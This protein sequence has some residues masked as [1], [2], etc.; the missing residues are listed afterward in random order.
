MI[1]HLTQFIKRN[2]SAGTPMLVTALMLANAINFVFSAI[3]GRA[4]SLEQF[5]LLTVI[6][7]FWYIASIFLN[8]LGATIIFLIAHEVGKNKRVEGR[9][10]LNTIR[11]NAT[12]IAVAATVVWV[13][14]IPVLMR[15][16]HIDDILSLISVAPL[17]VLGVQV[18]S[19]RA[20]LQGNFFFF[21]AGI[22]IV[23][24]AAA[25]LLLALPFIAFG[26][27]Q[28]VYLSIPLG[29][30][31]TF[32]VA[33]LVIS[34][35]ASLHVSEEEPV[36]FPAKHFFSTV[37]VVFS[38]T[39]FVTFDVLI[40]KHFLS[41][42]QAGVYALLSL[43]GKIVLFLG[44]IF[45]GFIVAY[46]SR[47]IGAGKS[48]TPVFYNILCFSLA[49]SFVGYLLVGPLGQ[50][51]LTLMLGE[52]KAL[53]VLQYSSRYAF[54]IMLFVISN[55]IVSYHTTKKQYQ[56][57]YMALAIAAACFVG[58]LFFHQSIDVFVNVV[59]I[60]SCVGLMINLLMHLRYNTTYEEIDHITKHNVSGYH[61][62]DITRKTDVA[63]CLTA[64]NEEKNI[65]NLL[66]S[67]LNQKT[68]IID[69]KHIVV[70]SFAST[71]NTDAIVNEYAALDPRIKLIQEPE[72]RG[73]ASAINTFLKQYKEP[74]VVVQS[75]DT[76][77]EP[78]CIEYLC[79]PM[80]ADSRI[81]M[82]GGAPVPTNDPHTF[83]GYV[84]H[85]WW[86]FHRNIPRFGEIIAFRNILPEISA[87]TAVDEAW[88]QAKFVQMNYKVVHIDD[89]VVYNKGSDT[90]ADIIK[91]RRRIYNGH[92]RLQKEEGVK[93]SHMTKSMLY[94]LLFKYKLGTFRHLI[95]LCG[96]ICIEVVAQVLG[97]WDKYMH[98]KNPVVWDIAS[99]TK[100]LKLSFQDKHR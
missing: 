79:R 53:S 22:L 88:I 29:M 30:F 75:T 47:A 23:V 54:A 35:K 13:L 72:R 57:S 18:F 68:S 41:A 56:F 36:A 78:H 5:A 2:I 63:I 14:M 15:L 71:D 44:S 9:A 94:L 33:L 17:F 65:G 42:Q 98:K 55:A 96:G 80:V 87:Q 97:R 77:C 8:G 64:Y 10:I 85:T 84:V 69:I 99:S 50:L 38:T 1:T 12:Y 66:Q 92:S 48:P 7:T 34:S 40:A 27:E 83:L 73:K 59:L 70:V 76:V 61:L 95:W 82:T 100:E 52:D 16:F 81:G 74:I 89:A 43:T 32:V 11:Q 49:A 37:L 67:L 20:Y 46:T 51:P 24:E 31:V 4:L 60:V 58:L 45:S 90:V 62:E 28:Y 19:S 86:W 25:K 26:Y 39:A 21:L 93:I 6:N 91:Q 3:L